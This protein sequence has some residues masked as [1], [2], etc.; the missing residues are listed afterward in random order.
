M[1]SSK[2]QKRAERPP[3]AFIFDISHHL[4][5]VLLQQRSHLGVLVLHGAAVD[6]GRVRC[7]HDLHSLREEGEGGEAEKLGKEIGR[8]GGGLLQRWLPPAGPEGSSSLPPIPIPLPPPLPHL[9]DHR[10]IQLVPAQP[11]GPQP[12]EHLLGGFVPLGLKADTAQPA[13][14]GGGGS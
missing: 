4:P 5:V 3:H 13:G 8:G 1:E 14:G 10:V 6:L 9:A 2:R 12:G 7:E 11:L